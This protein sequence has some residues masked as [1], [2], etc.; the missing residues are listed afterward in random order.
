MVSLKGF[1]SSTNPN[2]VIS[3]AISTDTT[4][5][6]CQTIWGTFAFKVYRCV[7]FA[8]DSFWLLAAKAENSRSLMSSTNESATELRMKSFRLSVK[9]KNFIP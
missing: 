2:M 1:R 5:E 3:I 7:N 8:K 9:L 6:L 4:P